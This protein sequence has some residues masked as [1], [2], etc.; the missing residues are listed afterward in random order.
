MLTSP[1]HLIKYYKGER[2]KY[3]SN[4]LTSIVKQCHAFVIP[5]YGEAWCYPAMES[6]AAGIPL[7]Y[8]KGTGID[9][10]SSGAAIAVASK[11]VF[12]YGAV[13]TLPGLC[14]CEDVWLEIDIMELQLSMRK[15]FEIY[16]T[17]NETY[18]TISDQSVDNASKFNYKNCEFIKGII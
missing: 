5:S 6:L 3:C 9:E 12:C 15:M 10:Y 8:T 13:D 14:T 1:L 17:E 16:A 18:K 11:P 7:I 4:V 2:R